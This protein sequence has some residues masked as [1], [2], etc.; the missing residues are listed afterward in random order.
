MMAA[1]FLSFPGSWMCRVADGCVQGS[2]VFN[3]QLEMSSHSALCFLLLSSSIYIY[4][5]KMICGPPIPLGIVCQCDHPWW[6][7]L[8]RLSWI[9]NALDSACLVVPPS[10]IVNHS[11]RSS[12]VDEF[13]KSL[14]YIYTNNNLQTNLE[15]QLTLQSEFINSMFSGLRSVWLNFMS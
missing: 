14:C 2:C 1:V 11:P 8:T 6:L 9:P 3:A 7:P 15:L 13:N 12:I 10:F 4:T 5:S